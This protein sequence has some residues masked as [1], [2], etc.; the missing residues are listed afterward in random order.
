MFRRSIVILLLLM[1]SGLSANAADTRCGVDTDLSGT[2]GTMCPEPDKDGDGYTSDGSLGKAGTTHTD[3][4]D[5][6]FHIHPG[7]QYRGSCSSGNYKT[8]NTDGTTSSCS[9]L[10]GLTCHTGGGSTYWFDAAETDCAGTGEYNDPENYLCTS[11]TG[12]SGYHAPVA[13]DCYVFKS[14]TY[15]GAWGTAPSRAQILFSNKDGTSSNPITLQ[16]APGAKWWEVGAG[17]GVLIEGSG[18]SVSDN[19]YVMYFPDS[20][21]VYTYGFEIK[22]GSGGYNSV[23]IHYANSTGGKTK[24]NY[25]HDLFGE[26]GSLNCAGILI[27][28]HSDDVDAMYNFTDDI[29]EVG[30]PGNQNTADI[31]VMDCDN[32]KI[33]FNVLKSTDGNGYGVKIKHGTRDG[34]AGQILHNIV[35]NRDDWPAISCGGSPNTLIKYNYVNDVERGC[36]EVKDLGSTDDFFS[37]IEIKSN[38]CVNTNSFCFGFNPDNLDVTSGTPAVTAQDNVCISDH[39]GTWAS[40]GDADS[41]VRIQHYGLNFL[42]TDLIDGNKIVIENNCIYKSTADAFQGTIFGNNTNPGGCVTT[43]INTC[44]DFGN[45]YNT[46]SAWQTAGWDT[47]GSNENPTLDSYGRATSTNCDDKGWLLTSEEGGGGGGASPEF[48]G[49]SVRRTNRGRR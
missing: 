5:T 20:E 6:N 31:V 39:S 46:W 21:Y 19:V 4:D 2:V 42:Y 18:S 1:I 11:N 35:E 15:T 33:N 3:C 48:S 45:V 17:S 30:E 8:C 26:C 41:E 24:E 23:G 9:A 14:G 16:A 12:M 13:G 34:T 38:T 49:R 28:G 25:T 47:G 22:T 37:G 43:P 36:F 32:F 29:Y 40:S 44:A 10:S 7:V 27:R